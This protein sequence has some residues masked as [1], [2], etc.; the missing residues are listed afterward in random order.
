MFASQT[1]LVGDISEVNEQIGRL[2]SEVSCLTVCGMR[3]RVYPFHFN[4]VTRDP[5]STEHVSANLVTCSKAQSG[6]GLTRRFY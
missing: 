2:N 5:L 3:D 4:I 6:Q 1:Y